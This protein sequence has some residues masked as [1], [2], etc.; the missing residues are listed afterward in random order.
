MFQFT[1]EKVTDHIRRIHGYSDEQMYL[2][3]GRSS[4][5]LIDTGT[6]IGNLKAYVDHFTKKP[7][8]VIL[9]HGHLDH[10][11][12]ADPFETV[13]I[14]H[15]DDE[16]YERHRQPEYREMYYRIMPGYDQLEPSD[17]AAPMD[18]HRAKDLVD[19]QVFDLGDITL[20]IYACPGHTP[21]SMTVLVQEE[22]IL[23]A[24]DACNPFTFLFFPEA[25]SLGSY[26]E[27]LKDYRQRVAGTYDRVLFSHGAVEDPACDIIENVIEAC[28]VVKRGEAVN[29]PVSFA[30]GTIGCM[31]KAINEQFAD[32][33]GRF[34]NVVYNPQKL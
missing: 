1:S 4:A 14:N 27:V 10:A 6:G 3:E 2:V 17:Y 28:E 26:E 32:A 25:L 34:G 8:T 31:A 23:I 11:L 29:I 15:A 13:Y 24:G 5:A 18:I 9:T 7:V 22:R 21:G 19:G 16:V 12:G 30:D 33:D 20:R